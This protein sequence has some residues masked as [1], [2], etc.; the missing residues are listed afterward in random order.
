MPKQAYT[1]AEIDQMR[2]AVEHQ[3]L[4]GR[5]IF[6]PDPNASSGVDENGNPWATTTGSSR[7]YQEEEKTVCVEELLRTYML[8]GVEPEDLEQ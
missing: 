7:A 4:Y 8:A 6:E 1:L 2:H 5:K 3:W